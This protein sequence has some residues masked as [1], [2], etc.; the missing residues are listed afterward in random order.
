MIDPI[1]ATDGPK[2]D[3][4]MVIEGHRCDDTV[5]TEDQYEEKIQV[6]FPKAKEDLIDFLNKCK[7]SGSLVML[8]PRCSVVFDKKAAK[9]VEGFRPKMG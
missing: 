8:C 3:V 2:V 7:I 1:V 9:N 4:E 6:V 5:I